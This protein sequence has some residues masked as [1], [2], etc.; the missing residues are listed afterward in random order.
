MACLEQAGLM[1]QEENTSMTSSK[2]P[3]IEH[4]GQTLSILDEQGNRLL[5][6]RIL[7]EFEA[8][9]DGLQGK[10][11]QMS[12]MQEVWRPESLAHLPCSLRGHVQRNHLVQGLPGQLSSPTRSADGDI[13]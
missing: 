8:N 1:E 9:P 5:A 13:F 11:W 10:T 6:Y 7:P 12:T 4:D 3:P 2:R